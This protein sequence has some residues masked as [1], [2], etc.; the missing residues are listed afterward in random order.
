MSING[1]TYVPWDHFVA[2]MAAANKYREA[3]E[4]ITGPECQD[5]AGMCRRIAAEALGVEVEA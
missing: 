5:R 4:R 1:E 3:L 2:Q